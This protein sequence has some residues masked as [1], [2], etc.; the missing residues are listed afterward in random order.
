MV[1][2][3]APTTVTR[4]VVAFTAST[5]GAL[6]EKV[7]GEGLFERGVKVTSLAPKVM[8]FSDK[9]AIVVAARPTV[10][11]AATELDE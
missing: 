8:L 4:P 11:T 6:L 3:P 10:T 2:V 9:F 1:A 5:V 7:K